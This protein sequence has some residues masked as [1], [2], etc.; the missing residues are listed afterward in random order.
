[1]S[2]KNDLRVIQDHLNNGELLQGTRALSR[3]LKEQPRFRLKRAEVETTRRA[4]ERLQRK[5]QTAR[6]ITQHEHLEWISTGLALLQTYADLLQ[7][8]QAQTSDT[9][10]ASALPPPPANP[11]LPVY[12]WDETGVLRITIQ[13]RPYFLQGLSATIF[14]EL[15]HAPLF[16]EQLPADEEH[17]RGLI[18]DLAIAL[19]THDRRHTT[20][21]ALNVLQVLWSRERASGMT[22][23]LELLNKEYW[24][25][26]NW[27]ADHLDHILKVYLT[28]LYLYHRCEAFR[29]ELLRGED[30][31]SAVFL[32]RWLYVS[33][34]HDLGH[35]FEMAAPAR[36]HETLAFIQ[37]YLQHFLAFYD[38]DMTDEL[39][40]AGIAPE[41]I[42]EQMAQ[43]LFTLLKVNIQNL[44]HLDDLALLSVPK[45]GHQ[46]GL[47]DLLDSL[48][49]QTGI[50]EHGISA[51]YRAC[52]ASNPPKATGCARPST[53]TAFS[54][55]CCCCTWDI[56][57]TPCLPRCTNSWARRQ[58][59]RS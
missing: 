45:N 46:R 7:E 14:H 53:I 1:M 52:Q 33:T 6:D 11:V 48:C 27:H 34:L 51:Y 3:L 55:L 8:V 15:V 30:C 29:H 49:Q 21:R 38:R 41:T 56:R 32:R 42:D 40:S 4:L 37:D 20:R 39:A 31:E 22:R 23:F 24:Q 36:Q 35:I 19:A 43:T 59:T 18:E 17:R 54:Q 50:G 5:W 2:L 58:N 12:Q 57:C 44:Q 47:L 9:Q 28:G 26:S 13:D 16:L 25:H 10:D